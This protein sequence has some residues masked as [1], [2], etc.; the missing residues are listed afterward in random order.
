[1]P[2]RYG[3][4]YQPLLARAA[5]PASDAPTP[6]F[7]GGDPF[8]DTFY[9]TTEAPKQGFW[10][11]TFRDK[12]LAAATEAP[13]NLLT[14]A[15]N[16]VL[17]P[18]ARL[19]GGPDH[20]YVTL[21]AANLIRHQYYGEQLGPIEEL[22]G[23][24][25][26]SNLWSPVQDV[27]DVDKRIT[28]R[29]ESFDPT[30]AAADFWKTNPT[31]RRAFAD[32]GVDERILL[33]A[34]NIDHFNYL[35][36]RVATEAMAMQRIDAYN[37]D[38][39]LLINGL[40]KVMSGVG[41]YLLYDP[42]SQALMLPGAASQ[43]VFGTL[44]RSLGAQSKAAAF[45]AN[46]AETAVVGAGWS[47]ADQAEAITDW[48][49]MF[50]SPEWQREFTWE[51]M[52][53]AAGFGVSIMGAL[54][55]G[56]RGVSSVAQWNRMREYYSDIHPM[57]SVTDPIAQ[58][59]RN[60]SGQA[61]LDRAAMDVQ[62]AAVSLLGEKAGDLGWTLDPA[63]LHAH[64]LNRL[65]VARFLKSLNE[66][67]GDLRPTHDAVWKAVVDFFEA[68]KAHNPPSIGIQAQVDRAPTRLRNAQGQFIARPITEQQVKG[69]QEALQH[70]EAV[71]KNRDLMPLEL[72]EVARM[73]DALQKFGQAELEAGFQA[74]VKLTK[75]PFS[76]E[77]Y[78]TK[79]D[80]AI[81]E[82]K[83]TAAKRTDSVPVPGDVARLQAVFDKYATARPETVA[84][85]QVMLGEIVDSLEMAHMNQ[86]IQD[87]TIVAKMMR[88]AGLGD[89]FSRMVTN[90]P[91]GTG[92][93]HTV[94]ST[95]GL[96]RRLTAELDNS[97]LTTDTV[98]AEPA[99]TRTSTHVKWELE[100][101]FLGMVNEM[102]RV[103][104]TGK[105]GN[106]W[107]HPVQFQQK[108][109]AFER[110]ITLH[111]RRLQASTD[112]DVL[113]L[114]R[115]WEQHRDEIGQ[116]GLKSGV[117]DK[118]EENFFPLRANQ[119]ILR[120]SEREA[121]AA[122]TSYFLRDFETG[123][124]STEI[125]W[126]TLVNMGW[127]KR[128]LDKDNPGRVKGWE[129]LGPLLGV[130]DKTLKTRGSL[131]SIAGPGGAAVSLESAYA[132]GLRSAVDASGHTAMQQSARAAIG[133][134]LG[135]DAVEEGANGIMKVV[136]TP[137][138]N[139]EYERFLPADM[140]T[141]PLTSKFLDNSFFTLAHDYFRGSG[142]R[143]IDQA[144]HQQL[145]GI[146]GL[147]YDETLSF[148]EARL[149]KFAKTSEETKTISAA[150]NDL[151]RK[152]YLMS[153]YLPTIH[154]DVNA[155]A[156]FL[157]QVT[158]G[159]TTMTFG[160]GIGLTMVPTEM[161]HSF[162]SRIYSSSDMFRKIR[163]AFSLTVPWSHD[164]SARAELRY[165]A[166][167]IQMNRNAALDRF[168]NGA[169]YSD[170]HWGILPKALHGWQVFWDTL[171]GR[172][173]PP[174][175]GRGMALPQAMKAL[176][177]NQMQLGALDYNTT[178]SR[179]LQVVGL[180]GETARFFPHAER[181]AI[182]LRDE[183]G[184]LDAAYNAAYAAAKTKGLEEKAATRMAA[185]A[186]AKVWRG[187]ARRAGFTAFGGDNWQ[188]ARRFAETGL[189]D[190][191]RLAVL[192][193]AAQK[194]GGMDVGAKSHLDLDRLQGYMRH[195]E[196][197]VEE[198]VAFEDAFNRLVNGIEQTM[199][200]RVSDQNIL[201]TPT[202]VQARTPIGRVLNLFSSYQRSWFDNNLLDMAFMPARWA[203][204]GWTT[205]MMGEMVN[206]TVRDLLRGQNIENIAEEALADPDNYILRRMLQ[207][208][209]L[210]QFT[211]PAQAMVDAFTKDG[212]RMQYDTTESA[213]TTA[214]NSITN[215]MLD[216]LHVA[217]PLAQDT[218][219]F[220]P[221]AIRFANTM[222][223][224]Y[225][226]WV[227]GLTAWG[228]NESAGIDLRPDMRRGRYA[229]R[230][231][232]GKTPVPDVTPDD[233]AVLLEQTPDELDFL[234]K[235]Q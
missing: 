116:I 225:K 117:L 139:T 194:T 125:H 183:G 120:R 230:P 73:R 231:Y 235:G 9:G 8:S 23:W 80:A 191:E 109:A 130:T 114:A 20:R 129:G 77:M 152:H 223:P 196:T 24:R 227:Y 90:W 220:G 157:T 93:F 79:L 64:N 89:L 115:M 144:R 53:L 92:Q 121:Q 33:D 60:A 190:V 71:A 169:S 31:M 95:F 74:Q 201:Q 166:T 48:N 170:F 7:F 141:N 94:R 164:A 229:S 162:W 2:N 199:K 44:G 42:V 72:D 208:A 68:G 222:I 198:A 168:A 46:A 147:K 22:S 206:R 133:R 197:A 185:T 215:F 176:G 103:K 180:T 216:A 189:L 113:A 75:S 63:A 179:T 101:R 3:S 213:G 210:G 96:L 182:I 110:A 232:V 160:A 187:F 82:V 202:T 39:P 45:F 98:S 150:I 16:N 32:A 159:A 135:A 156:E 83:R 35:W 138:P 200:K 217:S 172:T 142:F 67:L 132:A 124:H 88:S 50:D 65:Q 78:Q 54:H 28:F 12:W 38:A 43:A 126:D 149:L 151:R 1:M 192:R 86:P 134:L 36:R 69:M 29:D 37:A 18:V 140:I 58:S 56:G 111:I 19:L 4:L 87:M 62:E 104:K 107:L 13:G 85:R 105:F 21:P 181:M 30:S 163:K 127:A 123:T 99:V 26:L 128:I 224:G 119:G 154:D 131:G 51:H 34:R 66:G 234:Y 57:G 171:S 173:M 177:S 112:P 205:F 122:F 70:Y 14:W 148:A 91:T 226:S 136:R 145:W 137:T 47:F 186:K 59:F 15:A 76:V 218:G 203:I 102:V 27:S 10:G 158:E 161:A 188:V 193:R 165:I 219:G 228:L 6:M 5:M 11:V 97:K 41:N 40:S 175:G 118:L 146:P 108:I 167:A 100:R 212:R 61:V 17:D 214:A 184:A 106:P 221:Q 207:P 52:A 195:P 209:L 233:R 153:G 25:V 211:A 55:L 155:T 204:G 174:S 49:T 81:A 178:F 143:I 84:E